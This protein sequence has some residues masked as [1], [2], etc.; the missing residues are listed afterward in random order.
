MVD[1]KHQVR[2]GSYNKPTMEYK[3]GK[4]LEGGAVINRRKSILID[5]TGFPRYSCRLTAICAHAGSSPARS[6]TTSG[7]PS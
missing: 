2:A 3:S 7:L 6:T 1:A 5:E 4:K